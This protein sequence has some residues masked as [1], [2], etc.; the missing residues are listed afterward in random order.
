MV[1]AFV[2]AVAVASAAPH[3][4]SDYSAAAI[5]SYAAVQRSYLNYPFSS[6]GSE[7]DDEIHRQWNAFLIE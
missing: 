6:D 7:E 4:G 3:R 2:V 1:L 5:D